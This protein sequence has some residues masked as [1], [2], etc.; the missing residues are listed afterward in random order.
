MDD[1]L[2]IV[3]EAGVESF[4]SSDPPSW[5]LGRQPPG[6]LLVRHFEWEPM[7]AYVAN[8]S[9]FSGKME[10]YLRYKEIPYERRVV[11]MKV[12][13]DEVLPA[14][15]LMKVP[16]IRMA[17]GQWLKDTTPMIE[18]LEFQYPEPTVIPRDPVLRFLSKLVEDYADEW[19][20]RAA[21]YWRWRPAETRKLLM[22]RIGNEVLGDFPAPNR[23]AGWYYGRRQI[24]TYLKGDGMTAE[25]EPHIKQHYLD[26]LDNMSAI[27][28]EQ[29][30]LLGRH[31]SLVDIG[32]FGPMFRHYAQDPTP[33]R[34]MEERAPAVYAW[35]GRVWNSRASRLP[36]E[37]VFSDFSHR[38]WRY[39][40]KDIVQTY[41][42][43]LVRSARA[44]QAGK[45]RVDHRAHGVTYPKLR[46]THY[47][48]YCLQVLQNEYER[49]S[50]ADREAVDQT[51]APYGKLELLPGLRSGL[52]KEHELPLRPTRRQPSKLRRLIL[53]LMGTPW[54]MPVTPQE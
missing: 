10:A 47:R 25:T 29:P 27:L 5:T 14:S 50:N 52:M 23:L 12:M 34:V 24:A 3:D 38:G 36:G 8:M 2:D 40:L 37:P 26:L 51:L 20:W 46:V 4:P 44:W 49:L 45:K 9:Y 43:F 1:A 41:W 15:G 35:V 53:G 7:T 28:E 48:V 6:P 19:C 11:D 31:P 13:R 42:P 18:W 54:D 32:L 22:S 17:N 21:L 16:V 39:F 30:Y 33:S